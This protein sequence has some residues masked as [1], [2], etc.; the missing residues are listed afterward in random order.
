VVEVEGQPTTI[1]VV[2]LMG[3]GKTTVGTRLARAL[4]WPT[5][6]GDAVLE[7][8]TGDTAAE[9]AARDGVAALHAREAEVLLDAL[10]E[11]TPRVVMPAA[12]TIDDERCRAA[13]RRV[14]VVWL[15]APPEVLAERVAHDDGHRPLGPDALAELRAQEAER[16]PR[17]AALADLTVAAGALDADTIAAQVVRAVR[18]GSLQ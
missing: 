12:S 11:G 5:V 8:Q 2:G 15:D 1:A 14:F 7:Q 4:G 18:T 16:A 6:D 3:S 17:F 10:A 13:L 9:L